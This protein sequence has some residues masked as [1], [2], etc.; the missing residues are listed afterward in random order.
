MLTIPVGVYPF[1]IKITGQNWNLSI[2]DSLN[3]YSQH[4]LYPTLKPTSF[5]YT[6]EKQTNLRQFLVKYTAD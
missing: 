1:I 5:N 3:L 6:R 4:K 2:K